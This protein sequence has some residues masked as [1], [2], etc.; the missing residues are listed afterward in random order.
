[1]SSHYIPITSVGGNLN[2][3][4]DIQDEQHTIWIVEKGTPDKLVKAI[5]MLEPA[6]IL[7]EDIIEHLADTIFNALGK[8]VPVEN[9]RAFL[10]EL[11]VG[12]LISFPRPIKKVKGTIHKV[13]G[14]P[15]TKKTTKILS[16]AGTNKLTTVYV[17]RTINSIEETIQTIINHVPELKN[18]PITPIIGKIYSCP[19]AQEIYED[20]GYTAATIYC[21]TC[22]L[23]AQKPEAR[24]VTV[25]LHLTPELIKKIYETKNICPGRYIRERIE[26]F[27]E[28]NI[29]QI[30]LLTYARLKYDFPDFINF[31]NHQVIFDEA[32]HITSI[33][34]LH[35]ESLGWETKKPHR[36]II[37]EYI[38][39]IRAINFSMLTS[40]SQTKVEKVRENFC[41]KLSAIPFKDFTESFFIS[42]ELKELL[43]KKPSYKSLKTQID[44]LNLLATA[45]GNNVAVD[46]T[47]NADEENSVTMI[48]RKMEGKNV[49]SRENFRRLVENAKNTYLIDSTPY[50][51]D[52]YGFWLGDNHDLKELSFKSNYKFNI[53]IENVKRRLKDTYKDPKNTKRF[54]DII[55]GV[56]D[57]LKVET[58]SSSKNE[59]KK[60][61]KH[62]IDCKYAR[63]S[64]SEGVQSNKDYTLITRLPLQNISSEKYREAT[65]RRM[66]WQRG[67]H[68]EYIEINAMSEL[69]Q[70]AFRTAKIGKT[71]GSFWMSMDDSLIPKM[72]QYWSWLNNDITFITLAKSLRVPDKVDYVV[73][74]LTMGNLG[75]SRS[76]RV[77][78]KKI[79]AIF[80]SN[81]SASV[82]DCLNAISG[83]D[84]N[85]IHKMIKYLEAKGRLKLASLPK[86]PRASKA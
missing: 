36:I 56:N 41:S 5:G 34:I 4:I 7:D 82:N 11:A 52:Y 8:R 78:A 6:W 64:D 81:P 12:I 22:P 15:R 74:G 19:K 37:E 67:N 79:I 27:S 13:S 47:T 46:M 50:P 66:S 72:K 68:K 1:M 23:K 48:I 32:R 2:L 55:K 16:I 10:R 24:D 49:E 86:P 38:Q 73:Q 80:A 63:G 75:L 77:I 29:P 20:A 39:K 57:F 26:H 25:P 14:A 21:S 33:A 42:S 62:G 17:A 9:I 43:G 59:S 85:K 69:L 3:R 58:F 35:Q 40:K 31:N 84:R 28:R 30:I 61:S 71:S 65:I 83:H 76:E 60:L 44:F 54:V 51:Q 70:M 18:I 53:V 45:N